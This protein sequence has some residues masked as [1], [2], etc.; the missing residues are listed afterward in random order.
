MEKSV[1]LI[2][3]KP[4]HENYADATQS[5]REIHNACMAKGTEDLEPEW[6][7]GDPIQ[8]DTDNMNSLYNKQ[9]NTG[10]NADFLNSTDYAKYFISTKADG[11]RFMLFAGNKNEIRENERALYFIDRKKNYWFIKDVPSIPDKTCDKFLLDGELIFWGDISTKMN[12]NNIDEYVVTSQNADNPLIGFL[13]FDILYGPTNPEYI[14]KDETS[15]QLKF[16]LGSNGGM[17]GFKSLNKWPTT[18]RRFVLEEMFLSIDSPMYKFLHEKSIESLPSSDFALFVSPFI[19]METMFKNKFSHEIYESMKEILYTEIEKQYFV[20]DEKFKPN[21]EDFMLPKKKI[22]TDGLIFTPGLENYLFGPWML[23]NK[24]KQFKWKPIEQLTIDFEIGDPIKKSF[25]NAKVKQ[26]SGSTDFKYTIDDIKYIAVI[27]VDEN[28]FADIKIGDIVECLYQYPVDTTGKYI[29]FK[30]TK[31]RYDKI[32]PNA[33]LTAESVLNAADLSGNLSY[34]KEVLK[35]D[36][37]PN[38]LDFVIMMKDRSKTSKINKLNILMSFSKNKI[39]KCYTTVHPISIFD[40]NVIDMIDCVKRRQ[41]DKTGQLELELRLNLKTR[42]RIQPAYTNFLVKHFIT[43]P[44]TPVPTMKIYKNSKDTESIRSTYVLLGGSSLPEETIKKSPLKSI[45]I[46]NDLFRYNFDFVISEEVKMDKHVW[47]GEGTVQY[48]MRYILMNL[49]KFW[50]VEIIEYGS[51]YNS[52]EKAKINYEQSPNTRIDIEYDPGHFLKDIKKWKQEDIENNT[53]MKDFVTYTKLSKLTDK[54]M[55]IYIDNLN[56]T[57][58]LIVLREL[59][60]ILVKIFN[61]LDNSDGSKD[62]DKIKNMVK[63]DIVKKDIVKKP[64][65]LFIRMRKFHNYVKKSL[66]FQAAKQFKN[67]NLFDVSVGKG[68]DIDKWNEANI[69]EVYGIDPDKEDVET[70]NKRLG[71]KTY[72]KGRNYIFEQMTITDENIHIPEKFDIVSC[73]FTIHYFFENDDM[74]NNAIKNI[75]SALKTGGVF[76]GTTLIGD[77]VKNLLKNNPYPD[78]IKVEGN[79]K[80][81]IIHYLD[82]GDEAGTSIYKKEDMREYYVDFEKFESVCNEYKLKLVA[83]TPFIELYNKNKYKDLLDYELEVTKL[84]A[85]FVFKKI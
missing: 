61:A 57:N 52:I 8:L 21:K 7:G 44:Y 27:S 6:M 2:R 15:D 77:N 5:Y 55:K 22:D 47:L 48:Q 4:S 85:S 81:Y 10:N 1:K 36:T 68:G 66:I 25:Y 60:N 39:I 58:P 64:E 29:Y 18:R 32:A 62:Y 43:E 16:V 41:K 80:S 35:I 50:K 84:N 17:V 23:G 70:A 28:E 78:K 38:V 56:N 72:I 53:H 65:S 20:L 63:K 31:K 67:P 71:E 42:S 13:A 59:G 74:L 83:F 73:Q 54:D 12:G 24:N 79:N 75:S 19:D 49:S 69:N 37:N 45:H 76:I 34:M 26:G 82:N 40:E 3:L 51:D 14:K 11:I 33:F 46:S 30:I 9:D